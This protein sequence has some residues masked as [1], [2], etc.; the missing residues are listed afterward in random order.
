MGGKTLVV[1]PEDV[2]VP[3]AV[4]LA[5][6]WEPAIDAWVHL[7]THGPHLQEAAPREERGALSGL[8]FAVKDVVD[9]AGMP[10]RAGSLTRENAPPAILDAE[11]VRR[12]RQ[13]GAVPIGKTR[14]TEFAFIDPTTTRNPH[15][16]EHTPGGSSS[17]SGA[18]VGAGIVR[19]AIGTQT[20]GSLC[21][22]A[23]Y[24]GAASYKPS[25]GRIPT[26]GMVP[27]SQ[28]F[29]TVGVITDSCRTA[30]EVA[31]AIDSGIAA[32]LPATR[33]LSDGLRVGLFKSY[34]QSSASAEQTQ[35]LETVAQALRTL[36]C[37]VRDFLDPVDAQKV[38]HDHR[39]V[40]LH[41]A[42]LNH[43]ELPADQLQPKFR[44]ALDDGRKIRD[45]DLK[46]AHDALAHARE[47]FWQAAQEFDLVLANPVPGPAPHGFSGTGDQSYLTPWTVYQ[48]PL[49]TLAWGHGSNGMPL[50]VMLAARPGH[51]AQL[52]ASAV[53]LESVAPRLSP[54]RPPA[55]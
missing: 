53:A 28:S 11:I 32:E 51:D 2:S 14:T 50:G 35:A 52:L 13:A 1:A 8:A 16:L 9:V 12:M 40:M 15:N 3:D 33:P 42:V 36:G 47:A 22:P 4:D 20:A 31:V 6:Q 55:H 41:E 34:A 19:V 43:G 54:P 39:T 29:D 18:V 7:E 23:V 30:A 17:G 38:I 46:A 37:E 10:T 27:L 44:G 21:R 26:T 25:F 24:C 48:G 45:Q 5:L 49:V